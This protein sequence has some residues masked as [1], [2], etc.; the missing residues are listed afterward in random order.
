[1]DCAQLN[2]LAKELYPGMELF[3]ENHPS[4]ADVLVSHIRICDSVRI[5][6][7]ESSSLLKERTND[8]LS[9]IAIFSENCIA[10]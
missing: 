1:M 4:K 8:A 10:I 9:R 5:G 6:K 3:F 7:K 2:K